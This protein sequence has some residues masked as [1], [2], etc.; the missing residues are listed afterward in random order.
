M[1][2]EDIFTEKI[3]SKNKYHNNILNETKVTESQSQYKVKKDLMRI[4]LPRS[5]GGDS[6]ANGF[7]IFL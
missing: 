3:Y 2:G 4:K 6:T 1:D 5:I 7:W